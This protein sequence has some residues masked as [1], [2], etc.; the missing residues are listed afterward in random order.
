MTPSFFIV[1]V[2]KCGTSSLYRY[3]LMHPD[4]L[5]CAEK[6]PNF[7]GLHPPGYIAAHFD[8][9][10]A[11]FPR[12]DDRAPVALHW[13]ASDLAGTSARTTVVVEREA[14]RPYITGEATA[15]T[16]HDVDP[17]LLHE[18]LPDLKLV[19]IVREPVARAYS[20]HRMY[21]RFVAEGWAAG[22]EVGAF[23]ADVR[24]EI[25]KH[26]RGERTEYVGP[27]VYHELLARWA[28]VYGEGRVKVLVT[29][30]LAETSLAPGVMRELEDYLGLPHHDY[31]DILARRFNRAP[32]AS[33]PAAER[34]VLAD[35][36]RP[37]N[38]RLRE[39][40]GRDLHWD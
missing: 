17:A 16:W 29:E 22:F 24:A 39:I 12:L 18:H 32:P 21:R 25:A 33:I 14:Q 13:H 36:Y 8:E 7:F 27:G 15:S 35:F 30:D 9:Y 2:N 10:L 38:D 3:L 4:V 19:V 34:C 31:G 40:L 28:A 26:E 37:H 5:P 20:H 23:A 6:E 11:L 1:G